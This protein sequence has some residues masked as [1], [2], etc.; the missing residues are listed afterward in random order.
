MSHFLQT[1]PVTF[2]APCVVACTESA[3]LV[4]ACRLAHGFTTTDLRTAGSAVDLAAIAGATEENLLSTA[5][6]EE[7]SEGVSNRRQ[8]AAR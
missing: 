7:K 8:L 5:S 1:L 3:A 2:L 6:A 4:A